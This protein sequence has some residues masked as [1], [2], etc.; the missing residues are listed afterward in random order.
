[1]THL[2]RAFWL[3]HP[4][5]ASVARRHGRRLPVNHSRRRHP[6][7]PMSL[8]SGPDTG[9]DRFG[10]CHKSRYPGSVQVILAVPATC[11]T[12]EPDP[13]DLRS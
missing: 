7:G 4:V 6:T 13:R 10:G 1:M 3:K 8:A 12:A 2:L 11:H 5:R 9:G